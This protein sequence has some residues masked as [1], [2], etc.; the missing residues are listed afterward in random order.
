MSEALLLTVIKQID[1]HEKKII[2]LNEKAEA[3]YSEKFDM[4]RN[5]VGKLQDEVE[6]INLTQKRNT[7]IIR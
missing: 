2:E 6:K 3:H 4:R 5:T 7:T 1:A